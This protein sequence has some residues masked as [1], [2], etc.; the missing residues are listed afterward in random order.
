[1]ALELGHGDDLVGELVGELLL[2]F[3]GG[4]GEEFVVHLLELH[5]RGV[6]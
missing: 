3:L 2:L 4:F 1:V 5:D 6:V